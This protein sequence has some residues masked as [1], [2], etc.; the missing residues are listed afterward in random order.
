MTG[1]CIFRHDLA[2]IRITQ[3]TASVTRNAQNTA[4][5][6]GGAQRAP[7]AGASGWDNL[8]GWSD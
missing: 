1:D 6:N 8:T 5:V 4:F 7:N 3:S 2:S